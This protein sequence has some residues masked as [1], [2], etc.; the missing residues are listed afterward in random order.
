MKAAIYDRYGPPEVIR[1]T[2]VR[3]PEPKDDEILIEIHATTVTA[4]DWRLRSFDMPPGFKLMAQLMFGF[5][6]PRRPT[7]LGMELSGK[8]AQAGA[9]VTKFA[10]GDDVFA[11]DPHMGCNAEYKCMPETG[12]VVAKPASL[13]YGEAAALSF[14]GSTAL[15]FFRRGALEQGNKVLVNGASGGVGSAAVELA[16]RYFGADVTGVCSAANVELVES[17]GARRVIDYTRE[18]FTREGE[19]YDVIIDTAGTAPFALCRGSLKAGGRLLQVV[20]G[21]GDLLK[22]PWYSLTSDCKV[23]IG[24]ASTRL[25]D[26]RLLADLAEQGTFKPFIDRRYSLD[27]IVDAHRYVDTRRKRGNVVVEVLADN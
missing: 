24:P 19:R 7:I 16:A 9:R 23:I 17:L 12:T 6:R 14:G 4:A 21:L 26:L 1:L 3:K 11:F 8:V 5:S 2:E 25:E 15:S 20:G 13:S 18:D 10:V 27:Q 22:A